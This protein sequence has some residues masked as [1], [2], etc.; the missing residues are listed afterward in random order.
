MRCGREEL[1]VGKPEGTHR[2]GLSMK[3]CLTGLLLTLLV[4]ALAVGLFLWQPFT[5]VPTEPLPAGLV[6]GTFVFR[7]SDYDMHLTGLDLKFGD[8]VGLDLGS[9]KYTA[10]PSKL[11]LLAPDGS[12]GIVEGHYG[13]QR[14]IF[15]DEQKAASL[16]SAPVSRGTRKGPLVSVR[17]DTAFASRNLKRVTVV[18]ADSTTVTYPG[19][20]TRMWHLRWTP[21]GAGLLYAYANET[22]RS[23]GAASKLD[24]WG[25]GLLELRS[26]RHYCVLP[27]GCGGA[28]SVGVARPDQAQSVSALPP[29]LV[30]RLRQA[31]R[32]EE[33]AS[34]KK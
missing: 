34:R 2:W 25:L 21:D 23:R 15:A 28:P 7:P 27:G 9:L 24:R 3:Y 17:G 26:G 31:Q 16:T 30:E 5:H 22:P 10:L 29:A 6:H 1:R 8:K 4:G 14:I 13:K 18:R 19:P 20:G 32:E 11:G 33:A 12:W